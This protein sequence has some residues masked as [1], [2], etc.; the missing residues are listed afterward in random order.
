MMPASP[1][2]SLKITI[3][4][5]GFADWSRSLNVT[6]G[7]IRLNAEMQ[8]ASATPEPASAPAPAVV[9]IAPPPPPPTN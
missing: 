9:A 8:S 1:A 5:R 4:K 2:Q 3:R 6:S 7:Y